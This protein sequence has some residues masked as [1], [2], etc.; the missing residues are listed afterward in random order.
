MLPANNI[1]MIATKNKGKVKEFAQMFGRL[2]MEVRSLADYPDLPEV[3]EDGETFAENAEKKAKQIAERLHL[4]VLADDSGLSVDKLNGAPGV[5]SA[6]YAGEKASDEMNNAKM[7][8]ELNAL[9]NQGESPFLSAARFICAIAL[10]DPARNTTLHVEGSCNGFIVG[11]P[12]GDNGFGYDPLFY[13][14]QFDKTMAEL[15]LEQKNEI[16]HRGQAM[17]K[18]FDLIAQ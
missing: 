15:S 10:H 18:L 4:P 16:S 14:P 12:R 7:L 1:V 8:A 3:V 5:F 6:R 9:D 11:E 17:R 2:N 13:L